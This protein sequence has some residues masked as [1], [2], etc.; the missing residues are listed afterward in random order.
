MEE[1]VGGWVGGWWWGGSTVRIY[2]CGKNSDVQ[3]SDH[4]LKLR[5]DDGLS[6][7]L[8]LVLQDH[9]VAPRMSEAK[10]LTPYASKYDASSRSRAEASG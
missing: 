1:G 10:P 4:E 2:L 8:E 3:H 6:G 9:E 5:H 7:L